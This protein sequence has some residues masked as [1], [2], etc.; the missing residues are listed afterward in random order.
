[1]RFNAKTLLRRFMI[2][3]LFIYLAVLFLL[4]WFQRSLLYF[5]DTHI[6]PPAA[7]ALTELKDARI[8]VDGAG[9]VQAWTKAPRE[10]RPLI[11][12]FHGNGGHLGYRQHMYR[13]LIDAGY[14]LVALSYPGYGA[15]EGAP[16]EEA[17]YR[18]ARAAIAYGE[19]VMNTPVSRMIYYGES[20]GTGVAV[21][22]ATELP[23]GMVVLQSPFTSV[24]ARAQ[25]IYRFVPVA[26]LLKDRF[27][28]LGKI[29]QMHAPLLLFHGDADSIVP[30]A[31]GKALFERANQPKKSVYYPG[32]GHADFVTLELV[33]EVSAFAKEN[34]L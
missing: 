20:L 30:V 1:M 15:S 25:Q 18:S 27:D 11:V 12:Y 24:C 5:P 16:S 21:Q 28:S 33:K 3:A 10:G 23:P 6:N 34:G 4:W 32:I 2:T 7:Y 17:I 9:F 31:M 8:A 14:G 29:A 13:A 26:L 22:M 19:N